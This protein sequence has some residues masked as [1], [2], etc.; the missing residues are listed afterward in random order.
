[1]TVRLRAEGLV[2]H[3]GGVV[4]L[5]GVDLAVSAGQVV[6]LVGANG[7]GKTTLLDCLSGHLRPAGGRVWL[8]GAEIS[9][10]GP[11]PRARRGLVR[12]FQDARL[13]PTMPVADALVLASERSFPADGRPRARLRRLLP[14]R[15]PRD[16]PPRARAD[17][18]ALASRMGL[19]PL[20]ARP[21]GELSTGDRKRVDLACALGLRPQVLLLDEPSSGLAASEV[22]ALVESLRDAVEAS[23][24][25]VVMVEH[26]LPLVW[27]L[28]QWV[29]VLDRGAVV[30]AGPPASLRGHPALAFGRLG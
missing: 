27:S 9:R 28:A 18:A 23:G 6:G 3:F 1:V 24:A 7:A 19:G 12:T 26:D 11:G 5:D 29:V 13:F 10:L 2:V 14:S 4:A 25:A 15:S 21:V 8:G 20:L 22:P 16:R 17:G 30:A